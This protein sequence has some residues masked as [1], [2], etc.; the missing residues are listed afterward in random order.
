MG[1]KIMKLSIISFHSSYTTEKYHLQE[2]EVYTKHHQASN[3]APMRRQIEQDE[4]DE[5]EQNVMSKR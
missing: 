1:A 4:K 2:I 5:V 3:K